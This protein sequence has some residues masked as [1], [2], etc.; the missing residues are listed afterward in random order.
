MEKQNNLLLPWAVR[1]IDAI[2]NNIM[3]T[4]AVVP[5]NVPNEIILDN[6]TYYPKA[7]EPK[8]QRAIVHR[9]NTYDELV[10]ML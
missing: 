4:T 1:T 10:D 9:V 7:V 8:F 5:V 6:E 2:D 3:V